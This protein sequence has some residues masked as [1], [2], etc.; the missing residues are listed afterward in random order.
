MKK[1]DGGREGESDFLIVLSDGR[2][3][4]ED[5]NGARHHHAHD[6]QQRLQPTHGNQP[7]MSERIS[8]RVELS[9][10]GLLNMRLLS[11]TTTNKYYNTTNK[12]KECGEPSLEAAQYP[13]KILKN[14]TTKY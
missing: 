13:L 4:G 12:D 5:E 6:H 10:I 8:S 3:K 14:H 2:P 11:N 9:K 1:K 7:R